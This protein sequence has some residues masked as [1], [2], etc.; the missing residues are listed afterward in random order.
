MKKFFLTVIVA[1]CS[2]AVLAQNKINRVSP[3]EKLNEEYCTGLF[4]SSEG[5]ILDMLSKPGASTYFNILDWLDGRVSG[6]RIYKSRTG[7][8]LPFIRGQQASVYVDE[9]PVNASYLSS[10][11]VSEIAMIKIIKSP[12][13]G[14]FNGGGG[15]IAIYTIGP[16][17]EVVEE[18]GR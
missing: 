18:D 7:T 14:G 1:F 16:E 17:E 11:P 8:S 5:T 9:M 3:E 12:F 2:I 10:L 4:K 15:A 13:L 6:L